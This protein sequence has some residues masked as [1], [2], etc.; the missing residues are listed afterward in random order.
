MTMVSRTCSRVSPR[1]ILSPTVRLRLS[2]PVQVRIGILNQLRPAAITDI[3]L[4][5]VA[6]DLGQGSLV[7]AAIDDFTIYDAAGGPV[8]VPGPNKLGALRLELAQSS[9]VLS[10]SVVQDLLDF[11]FRTR[12]SEVGI[13][14]SAGEIP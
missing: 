6:S 14:K 13:G 5:F 11:D 10:Q 2:E 1:P 3:V 7:E 8:A 9:P 12:G 4:R